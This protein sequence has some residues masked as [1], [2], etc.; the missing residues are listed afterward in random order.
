MTKETSLEQATKIT[1]VDAIYR[2]YEALSRSQADS[3]NRGHLGASQIGKE[4]RRALWYSFRWSLADIKTGRIQRLLKRGDREEIEFIKDLQAIGSQIYDKDCNGNQFSFSDKESG[5]H[6]SCSLDGVA[7]GLPEEPDR[8]FLLEFKTVSRKYFLPLEKK[9][10][11]KAFPVY[12]AQMQICMYLTEPRLTQSFFLA[13]NKN[14]EDLYSEI[15]CYDEAKAKRLMDKA[16]A[17]IASKEPPPKIGP[18]GHHLCHEKMCSFRA[19]CHE[20]QAPRVNCRTCAHATP[21]TDGNAR[22]SCAYHQ[23]DLTLEEQRNGCPHHLYIPALL[24]NVAIAIDSDE[25]ENRIYYQGV[26][27]PNWRFI[28]GTRHD[29]QTTQE[30]V[31]KSHEIRAG[32]ANG[33]YDL[34]SDE[35]LIKIRSVFGAEFKERI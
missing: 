3:N 8:F 27:D 19:I 24:E 20:Q 7:K 15:I 30:G 1:T 14:D 31:L 9:G 16:R 26:D 17:I 25:E 12:Y 32:L 6:I 5:H 23:E 10:L 13:V 28:N 35:D 29:A 2:H 11:E 4:C 22:W 21:E 34:W 18:P 33:N